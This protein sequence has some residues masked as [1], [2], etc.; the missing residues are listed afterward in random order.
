MTDKSLEES[1][2]KDV[3]LLKLVGM[4][5]VIVHG[6]G[7][8][9]SRW[10]GKVG[11]EP[12]F[13]DGFRVTDDETMEI[14]EMVLNRVNKNLVQMIERL[15]VKA[16]GISG[17][18]AGMMHAEKKMPNGND[19]GYVGDITTVN[20]GLVSALLDNDYIP[21][22]APIAM[23]AHGATYNINADDA[24]SAVAVALGAEKLAFLTDVEGVYKDPDDEESLISV[25]TLKQAE[26]LIEDGTI[27]GGM[28][29]KI[30]NCTDAVKKGVGRVHI[31]DGRRDHCLLLEFFT[32]K[33]VGTAII[34][35][36]KRLYYN[37][38]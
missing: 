17:K 3:V 19:I 10:I 21:V 25:L 37:E 28:L 14:A 1:V 4:K 9:I 16:V 24:A 35:G 20:P 31:L 5:P 12:E 13:I 26:E 8:E 6:G 27:S 2:I 32:K 15:G 36:S 38:K 22:I 30:L 7:K 18:D 23:G 29:P 34:D 11:K 33:G